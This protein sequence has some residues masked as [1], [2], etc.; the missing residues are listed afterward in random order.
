M[1]TTHAQTHTQMFMIADWLLIEKK[2]KVWFSKKNVLRWNE[3]DEFKNF[4]SISE[5]MCN[6][7]VNFKIPNVFVN[8]LIDRVDKQD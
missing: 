5:K 1:Y 8:N 3:T 2:N 4:K 7:K 6:Q